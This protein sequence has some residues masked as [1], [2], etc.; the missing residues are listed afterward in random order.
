MRF[1]VPDELALF[2]ESVRGV[3]GGWEP[4][5]EPDL[6]AWLDDRD[7]ALAARLAE[8]GW[9]DLGADADALGPTVAGAFELGRA[10]APVCLLDE[11]TLGGALWV[12]GRARH[13]ERAA[14][15]AVPGT[16]GALALASS[17]GEPV[18]ERTLDGSGVVHVEVG[19]REELS[20]AAAELRLRAWNAATLAY[21]AGLA[22]RAL[23]RAVEHVR[24]R[25]QFGA[26]LAALPTVQAR[27]ADAA[28]ARDAIGL[29][30][31][32][33]VA[34]PGLGHTERA[35]AGEGCCDVTSAAHQVH[36]A[37]GFALETGLHRLY[38]RSRS[39]AAWSAA[40]TRA[41]R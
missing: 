20:P 23:E 28:L 16:G 15:L 27:L 26:P 12:G 9:A 21:L 33:A 35:W 10:C 3:V 8:A 1:V 30:A 34:E 5:R 2:A 4:E 11:A 31:W 14:T 40:L 29:L 17:T 38:R 7:D 22:D 24:S 25:E 37:L 19:I 41:V 6:G 36:G 18:R 39:V 32:Q 13:G